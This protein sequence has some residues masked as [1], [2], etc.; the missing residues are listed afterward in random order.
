MIIFHHNSLFKSKEN[1]ILMERNFIY[2]VPAIVP[3]KNLPHSQWGFAVDLDPYF[4]IKLRGMNIS[5]ERTNRFQSEGREIIKLHRIKGMVHE[6]NP[7]HFI[8][9]SP[10]IQ[11]VN[12][13]GDAADL[14]LDEFWRDEFQSDSW[15]ELIKTGE[16]QELPPVSYTPHNID[17]KDQAF[18]LLSLWLNWANTAKFIE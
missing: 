11:G 13:P 12:V 4:A 6:K 16:K 14:S 18:C 10:L 5:P 8:E 1:S 9:E 15:R 7:H 3:I 17:T 2:E